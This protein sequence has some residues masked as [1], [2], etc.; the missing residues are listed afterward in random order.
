MNV[1]GENIEERTEGLNK[2]TKELINQ[3][4]QQGYKAGREQG[5]NDGY[6]D[7]KNSAFNDVTIDAKSFI[8]QGRNEAWE[9]IKKIELTSDEGGLPASVIH[10]IFGV[11]YCNNV[12][13]RFSASEVIEKIKTYEEH[14]K[15]DFKVGDIIKMNDHKAVITWCDGNH[16]N[17][18][19]LQGTDD[20]EVGMTYH[21]MKYDGWTKTGKA[22]PSIMETLKVMQEG[23]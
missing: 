8:E 20:S 19:C 22:I 3:V 13:T 9:A 10:N 23:E 16:W 1:W 4:Y 12:L 17:G 5:R 18:I 6:E 7:W 11:S 15:K 21:S 2:Q 14:Q